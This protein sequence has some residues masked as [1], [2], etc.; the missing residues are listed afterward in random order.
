MSQ[1]SVSMCELAKSL[2]VG[3]TLLKREFYFIFVETGLGKKSLSVGATL[4]KREFYFIFV[5]T[6]LG[7]YHCVKLFYNQG[8]KVNFLIQFCS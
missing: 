4:L 6:G 5:E 1:N 3:T 7:K 2:S 8:G